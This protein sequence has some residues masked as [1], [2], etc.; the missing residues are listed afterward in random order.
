MLAFDQFIQPKV[1]FMPNRLLRVLLISFLSASAPVALYAQ[2]GDYTDTAFS[3]VTTDRISRTLTGG[4]LSCSRI[5]QDYQLDCYRQTFRRAAQQLNAN[6]AYSDMRRILVGVEKAAER[7]VA[8]YADTAKPRLRRGIQ[9]FR[10]TRTASNTQARTEFSSAL[11][12]ALAALQ[13]A[14]GS[15]KPHYAAIAK[16]LESNQTRL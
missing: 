16:A 8:Q 15:A 5:D 9:K 3:T 11:E 13:L 12:S 7:S 1:H 6:A 4:A 14:R 2:G 10:A